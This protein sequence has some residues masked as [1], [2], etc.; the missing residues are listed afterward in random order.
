MDTS[1]SID[2]AS[3]DATDFP[4]LPRK[5]V[6]D[7]SKAATERMVEAGKR[8]L[9]LRDIDLISIKDIATEAGA[10]IGSFYHRFGTKDRYFRYLVD[11]MIA[12]REASAMES[13]GRL[14][15]PE[16]PEALARGA[17]ANHSL[18]AGL[19]RSAIR[20]HICGTDMWLPIRAMGRR[21]VD[22]YRRRAAL[23]IGRPLTREESERIALAFVWLYGS[24]AQ[25]VIQ[26]N[27]ISDYE[28]EMDVFEAEAVANF[29]NMLKHAIH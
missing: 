14:S 4:H 17:I 24:L 8:L 1:T 2:A 6:Q 13:Y 29:V 12:R 22:E 27:A 10:S 16:L 18:H 9:A 21:L 19:L 11:D 5:P 25:S 3:P 23:Y 20:S 28:I 26:L 15:M 7:R